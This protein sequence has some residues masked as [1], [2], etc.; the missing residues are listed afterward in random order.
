MKMRTRMFNEFDNLRHY[1]KDRRKMYDELIRLIEWASEDLSA[2]TLEDDGRR[3]ST[4]CPGC[5]TEMRSS[6]GIWVC[7]DCGIKKKL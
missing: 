4:V 5:G 6:G 2:K 3:I 1:G 7:I